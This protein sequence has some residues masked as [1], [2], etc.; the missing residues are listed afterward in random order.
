MRTF[1]RSVYMKTFIGS[2][3]IVF[4]ASMLVRITVSKQRGARAMESGQHCQESG[5]PVIANPYTR[6]DLRVIWLNGWMESKKAVQVK[7]P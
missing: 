4:A 7:T 2:F 5:I 1:F 3:C 6:G